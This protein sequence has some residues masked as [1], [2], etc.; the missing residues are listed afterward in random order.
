LTVEYFRLEEDI[1]NF[2]A[3]LHERLQPH[4]GRIAL[5]QRPGLGLELDMEAIGRYTL[6]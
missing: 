6:S 3:L 2:E 4:D 1:Y 5:P